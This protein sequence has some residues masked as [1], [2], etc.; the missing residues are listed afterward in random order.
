MNRLDGLRGPFEWAPIWSLRRRGRRVDEPKLLDFVVSVLGPSPLAVEPLRGLAAL[1]PEGLKVPAECALHLTVSTTGAFLQD[2]RLL[3][4]MS[5]LEVDLAVDERLHHRQVL[6]SQLPL[7]RRLLRPQPQP[8]DPPLSHLLLYRLGRGVAE[9]AS[10]QAL[11][12]HR[13]LV[14]P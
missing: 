10:V 12:S 7:D 4:S 9:R 11:L 13:V 1:L 2:L 14:L 8:T 5:L 6:R 3:L